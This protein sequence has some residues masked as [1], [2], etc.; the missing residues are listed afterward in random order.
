MVSP[1]FRASL[2]CAAALNPVNL[3]RFKMGF[4]KDGL[5]LRLAKWQKI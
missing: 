4:I 3:V 2:D 5:K 1:L